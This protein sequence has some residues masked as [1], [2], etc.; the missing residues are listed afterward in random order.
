MTPILDVFR[1][2][3]APALF[4]G[5]VLGASAGVAAAASHVRGEITAI[6]GDTV[7]VKTAMGETVDVTTQPDFAVILY[8]KIRFEDLKPDDYLS[9]PSVQG[10][11]GVKQALAVNVF[12]PEMKGVR[13]GES[14]WDMGPDSLMTNATL[15]TMQAMGP[16]HTIVVSYKGE[17]ETIA[18]PEGT[19][20]SRFA[21]APDHALTVGENVTFFGEEADGKFVTTRGGVTEDGSAPPI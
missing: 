5:L 20:I 12:P 21:P 4:A 2:R 1:R 13:E 8:Q 3:V 16:A 6:S 19:P 10:A 11:D 9:I 18:V 14:P 15:G 7:T 17:Q